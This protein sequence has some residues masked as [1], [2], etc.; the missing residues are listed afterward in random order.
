MIR[1]DEAL[2]E[3]SA[4]LPTRSTIRAKFSGDLRISPQIFASVLLYTLTSE[5]KLPRVSKGS[6]QNGD[7]TELVTYTIEGSTTEVSSSSLVSSFTYGRSLVPISD[8]LLEKARLLT[9]REF[10]ILGTVHSSKVP[11]N[12]FVSGCDFLKAKDTHKLSRIL[13]TSLAAACL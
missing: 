3:S 7:I 4:I 12:S 5:A 13:V 1:V 10:Y 2:L 8:K 6:L 9:F 11:R